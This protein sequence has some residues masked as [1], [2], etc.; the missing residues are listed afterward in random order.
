LSPVSSPTKTSYIPPCRTIRRETRHWQRHLSHNP[1]LAMCSVLTNQSTP[2]L[3][4]AHAALYYISAT[5]LENRDSSTLAL[6]KLNGREKKAG[7]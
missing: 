1:S 7:D 6:G 5:R 2:S 4:Q 3:G